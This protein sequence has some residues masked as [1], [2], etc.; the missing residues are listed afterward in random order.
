MSYAFD[1]GERT[2]REYFH[3]KNREA[4]EKLREKM[5]VAEEAKAAG[6]SSRAARAAME[7]SRKASL[8]SVDRH[9]R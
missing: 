7:L 8:R 3:R 6:T 2:G 4:F 1:N 5:K 9:L